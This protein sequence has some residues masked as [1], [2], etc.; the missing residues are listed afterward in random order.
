MP[1][2]ALRKAQ[3]VQILDLFGKF[4]ARSDLYE[5]LIGN[6]VQEAIASDP[7][8]IL[9]NFTNVERFSTGN[10]GPMG[11]II[12][13]Y[14]TAMNRS[15]PLK[16]LIPE[17]G[18]SVE[19][20]RYILQATG[21]EAIFEI[22]SDEDI[23]IRSFH[24][25]ASP[26]ERFTLTLTLDSSG[27]IS[28]RVLEKFGVGEV[29]ETSA[30]QPAL[31]GIWFPDETFFPPGELREFEGLL[32][33]NPSAPEAAFQEF[34]EAH[35]RWLYLLGE[36]YEKAVPQVRLPPLE[37]RSTLA[38]TEA[39]SADPSA[40]I[41]DFL[42]KRIGLD[43][44]DVLDI[45]RA[46]TRVIV[47][48]PRRRRFSSAVTEAIAQLREYNRRLRDPKVK[49]YLFERHRLM[50]SE[51]MAMVVMGRDFAFTGPAE[52]DQFREQ[53]GVRIYTYDDLYRL[54]KRRSV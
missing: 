45:K 32:N 42:V 12:A 54:A 6:A 20:I 22:F 7:V 15:L 10:Y 46:D 34:F 14:T 35:P 43:L 13:A 19:P 48:G 31:H 18:K 21:L 1:R 29:M 11:N 23:A 51:P 44:W 2:I 8:G 36:Q 37:A 49:D 26:E 9:L 30:V 38:L 40:L 16:L 24:S 27:R 25:V 53:L 33:R 3:G 41:P 28:V 4:T 50:V 17:T 5:E 52:K 47:G 39:S